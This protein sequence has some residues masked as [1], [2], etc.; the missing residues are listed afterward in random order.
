MDKVPR[1]GLISLSTRESGGMIKRTE[2]E[3]S[4]MPTEIF[5]KASGLTT[6]RTAS[7]LTSTLTALS[8]KENGSR[9]NRKAPAK[10]LGLMAQ[11]MRATTLMARSM[12]EENL[13]L[14]MDPFMKESS[15]ITKL[16]ELGSIGGRMAKLMMETGGLTR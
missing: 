4:G 11:N 14:L 3:S 12:A 9:T 5:T 2:K 10:K 7:E 1:Y 6:E 13:D 15:S 16:T 8:T